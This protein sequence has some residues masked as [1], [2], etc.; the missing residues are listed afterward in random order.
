MKNQPLTDISEEFQ[1]VIDAVRSLD[2][3]SDV[4]ALGDLLRG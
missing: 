4:R 1:K 3:M 2:A